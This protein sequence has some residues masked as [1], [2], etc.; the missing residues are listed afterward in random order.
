MGKAR[1]IASGGLMVR[2]L[3]LSAM[4]V[5]SINGMA[6]GADGSISPLALK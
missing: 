5:G 3:M 2:T 4:L 1:D 6:S